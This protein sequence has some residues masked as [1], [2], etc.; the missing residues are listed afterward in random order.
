MD[1][2]TSSLTSIRSKIAFLKV[3][4]WISFELTPS[5]RRVGDRGV[6]NLVAEVHRFPS[7]VQETK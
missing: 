2:E 3:V 6:R 5:D 7:T 1:E 4:R